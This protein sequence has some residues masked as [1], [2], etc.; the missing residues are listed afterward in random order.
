MCRVQMWLATE[1]SDVLHDAR[2][3]ARYKSESSNG[4]DENCAV[5]Q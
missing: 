4:V 3:Q 1:D 5:P 2:R